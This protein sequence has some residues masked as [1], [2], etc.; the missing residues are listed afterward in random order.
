MLAILAILI[1][2]P[3]KKTFSLFLASFLMK[4]AILDVPDMLFSVY[5]V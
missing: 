1:F 2:F 4:L 3:N 5:R